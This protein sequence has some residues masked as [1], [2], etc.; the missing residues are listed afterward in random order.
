MYS[1]L[2]PDRIVET[3]DH[4]EAR[5]E[6]SFPESGLGR[7]TAELGTLAREAGPTAGWLSRPMWLLRIGAVA[8]VLVLAGALFAFAVVVTGVPL[9]I[10]GA[11]ELIQATE[12]AV[13]EVVL[14]SLAVFFLLS[15][16]T[17]VKRSRALS[18]LHRLRSVV[19]IVDMHQLTKDPQ[20]LLAPRTA[21]PPKRRYTRSELARYLD[22]CSELLS[23]ASKLAA[24]HVQYLNDP[25]VLAAVNDIETLAGGLSSKIWQKIMILDVMVPSDHG[26]PLTARANRLQRSRAPLRA[27]GRWT[28]RACRGRARRAEA[29]EL[30][31]V[32]VK[33]E[34]P[35]RCAS[36]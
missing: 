12:S 21:F 30:S 14:L 33:A 6:E 36:C 34:G 2:R 17:R 25:V 1:E 9:R 7:L 5:I 8:G 4:L 28:R 31:A 27:P 22:F 10:N 24:L 35:N 29:S 32:T 19:H 15:L 3:I 23:L 13:N 11:A 18:A 26:L 20:H 16:E